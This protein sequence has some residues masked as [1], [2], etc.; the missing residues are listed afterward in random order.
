MLN[1]IEIIV[2]D[3]KICIKMS[4]VIVIVKNMKIQNLRML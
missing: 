4:T 3:I 1:T 2:V